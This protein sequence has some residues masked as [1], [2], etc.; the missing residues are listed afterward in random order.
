ML[1]LGML[2]AA[3]SLSYGGGGAT[4]VEGL[5]ASSDLPDVRVGSCSGLR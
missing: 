1:L 4:A 5:T 3:L 2:S